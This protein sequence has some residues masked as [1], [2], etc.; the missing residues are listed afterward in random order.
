MVRVV[1]FHAGVP[2]LNPGR[3]KD[4]PH[5]NNFTGGSGNWVLPELASGS[6]RGATPLYVCR[7]R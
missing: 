7:N 5:C 1:D 6:D 3:P 4:F 2:G